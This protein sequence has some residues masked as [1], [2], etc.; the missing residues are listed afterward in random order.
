[1]CLRSEKRK[2]SRLG[3]NAKFWRASGQERVHADWQFTMWER[4][5]GIDIGIDIGIGIEIV[6]I[7]SS[8]RGHGG[9]Y[10]RRERPPSFR[11]PT[12]STKV[13]TL[14]PLRRLDICFSPVTSLLPCRR[15]PLEEL[16]FHASRIRRGLG[17]MRAVGTLKRIK[18]RS[19][20]E[21]WIASGQAR[22]GRCDR[23]RPGPVSLHG[24]SL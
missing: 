12:Y 16:M 15:M 23:R 14:S 1:M 21:C 13:A 8:Y 10:T 20:A 7:G 18:R 6:K 17:S 5:I 2:H 4:L 24:S 9:H 19:A 3:E 22:A 11:H